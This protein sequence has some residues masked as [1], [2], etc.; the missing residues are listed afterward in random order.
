[1][2]MLE[3]SNSLTEVCKTI[4]LMAQVLNACDEVPQ[5][6]RNDKNQHEKKK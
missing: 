6:A 2:F 1:M 5:K 4:C 3:G